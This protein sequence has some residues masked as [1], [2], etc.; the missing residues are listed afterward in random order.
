MLI[1]EI[2]SK[3]GQ[4]DT[5]CCEPDLSLLAAAQI[6]GKNNIGALPVV[7]ADYKVVG[8]LSERDI[9]RFIAQRSDEFFGSNV[10]AAMTSN[11]ITCQPEDD[12]ADIFQLLKDHRIRHVPVIEE[13]ELSVML[14]IRDFD[15]AA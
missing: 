14:S 3:L 9:V 8:V 12:V 13:H 15:Q 2:V 6:L 11:V 5:F 7:D 4:V 1:S 10:E